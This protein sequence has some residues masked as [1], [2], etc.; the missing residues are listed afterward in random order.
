MSQANLPP[1]AGGGASAVKQKPKMDAIA[2]KAEYDQ[3]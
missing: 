2:I 3:K 1:L